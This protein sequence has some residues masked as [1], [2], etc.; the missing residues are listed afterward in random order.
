MTQNSELHGGV[1]TSRDIHLG[2]TR[3]HVQEWGNG[4]VLLC[5]HGLGGGSHFFAALGPA[6]AGM[7]RTIA[8]DLPGSGLSPSAHAVS[9]DGFAELVIRVL[10]HEDASNA[11]LLGH[12]MGTIIA[13]EA[14]RQ[15]PGRMRGLIAVGGLPEPLPPARARLNTRAEAVRHGGLAGLGEVAAA[16]NF[17]QRT[18]HERPE[19]TALF[20]RLFEMQVA[21]AYAATTE[22][23][24]R[25]TARPL[26]SLTDVRCLAITGREDLYAPPEAVREFAETLPPGTEVEIMEDCGHLPFLERPQAFAALV[27]RFITSLVTDKH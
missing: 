10:D 17:S 18:Q 16:A 15:A 2:A 7:C 26:P 13:L 22:I 24:A 6:L 4:P 3:V 14:V 25:W 9:F 11:C 5:L 1:P 23:L 8:V 12:S 27:E 19:L 20:A 21:E